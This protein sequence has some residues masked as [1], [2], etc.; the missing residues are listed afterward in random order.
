MGVVTHPD[1]D[2]R[3]SIR[4][5]LITGS[6]TNVSQSISVLMI[7]SGFREDSGRTLAYDYAQ[8]P[9]VTDVG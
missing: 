8:P 2:N 3:K 1:G 5:C 6:G 9:A 4:W 7:P